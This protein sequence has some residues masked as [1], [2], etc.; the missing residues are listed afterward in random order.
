VVRTYDAV[1]LD[2]FRWGDGRC[3]SYG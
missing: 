2:C 3:P 1:V